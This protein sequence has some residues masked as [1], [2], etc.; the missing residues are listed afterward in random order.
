MPSL[1]KQVFA[2][3]KEVLHN[4]AF[5]HRAQNALGDTG[6]LKHFP[7]ASQEN[8][9]NLT[10][11]MTD[12]VVTDASN[13]TAA[14]VGEKILSLVSLSKLESSRQ[15][16]DKAARTQAI[17]N[18]EVETSFFELI[19]R[20]TYVCSTPA[21]LGEAFHEHCP[22]VMDD[23]F[24][25]D[26]KFPLM[27]SGLPSFMLGASKSTAARNRSLEAV[28]RWCRAYGTV[29]QSKDPGPGWGD[30][31]DVSDVVEKAFKIWH[32]GGKDTETLLH[33]MIFGNLF[34]LHTVSK[35]HPIARPSLF[36]HYVG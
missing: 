16:W 30:M 29:L 18:E 26:E 20:W 7:E 1:V 13:R 5:A 14:Q 19:T 25:F 23:I 34:A 15:L 36:A 32:K 6:T 9:T 22:S 12:V 4:H 31:N 27:L 21:L 8:L 24:V 35:F 17:G 10:R 11:L 33:S 3:R 28:A 2:Q